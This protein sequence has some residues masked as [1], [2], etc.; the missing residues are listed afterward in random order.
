MTQPKGQ[1]GR[2]QQV[3]P[4]EERRRSQRVMVR[5][6]VTLYVRIA[7]QELTIRADTVAVND[8]G[9]MLLCSRTLPADTKLEIQNDRTRQRLPCRVTRTPRDTP[10]GCLIPIEF[11]TPSPGFWHISFPPTNWKGKEG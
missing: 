2:G 6:P 8:H 11:D 9:A 5:T 3:L 4:G 7:N 1:S 10:E